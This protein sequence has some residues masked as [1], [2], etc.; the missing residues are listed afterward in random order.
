MYLDAAGFE[1]KR[2]PYEHCRAPRAR[3]WRLRN[4]GL[5]FG[6]TAKGNTEGRNNV[7]FMVGISHGKG[8]ILCERLVC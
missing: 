2:N 3:E 4:E 6:C 5:N 8:V 7:K 1:W